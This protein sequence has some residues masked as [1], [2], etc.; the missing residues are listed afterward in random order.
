M[1]RGKEGA[2]RCGRVEWWRGVGTL[3][4]VRGYRGMPSTGMADTEVKGTG[5]WLCRVSPV[6]ECEE[7]EA[8]N[9]RTPVLAAEPVALPRERKRKVKMCLVTRR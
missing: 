5:G 4:T 1:T 7:P 9:W 8:S 3:G 6:L 2:V